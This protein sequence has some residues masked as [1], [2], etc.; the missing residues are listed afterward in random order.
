MTGFTIISRLENVQ[1]ASYRRSAFSNLQTSEGLAVGEF[2]GKG[3]GFLYM[4]DHDGAFSS[5]NH[6][7]IPKNF[8]M[9][10]RNHAEIVPPIVES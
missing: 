4:N 2:L 1:L 10:V 7:K 6:P 5:S 9:F 3:G 8:K